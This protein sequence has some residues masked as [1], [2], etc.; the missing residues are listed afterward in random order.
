M[1]SAS[2]RTERLARLPPPKFDPVLP[3][4]SRREEIRA[5]IERHQVVIV[6]GETGS[7]KTTQLPKILLEMGRGAAGYIGHTQ[8]RR[9]AARSVAARIAEELN[10]EP[11]SVVGYKVRFHD[12]LHADS[13]VKLM[14][15]GILL[16]ETQSDPML[17]QYDSIIIDEAHERSLNIDFLLGYLKRL[18]PQR[19]DLKLVVTS[20]TI[21]AERFARHFGGAPVIEVSGRLYPVEMRYRPVE[22][23][24]EDTTRDEE[25]RALAAAVDELC[26]EGPGDVLV[27][28]PGEREIRDAAE[29]LRKHHP[30]HT[31]ILPLYS[32]LS[33]AE[34][35]R[36]FRPGAAR[37][38]VLA[39]NVAETS[40]TVPRIRYVV[41]T[42]LA[43]VK[44]YSYR[45]KVEQ[46]RVENVS[47][48]AATQRAGRCGR[49]RDGICVRL[50]SE[51]DYEGR[52]PYSEPEVLRSSLA[53]VILRA[54]SL[55]LGNVEEFPFL[56]PPVPRAIADGYALLAELG[57]VDEANELTDVGRELARLPLDPRVGR[58]LIAARREG[59]L[60][61]VLV[62]AAALSAQD[63]RLRPMENPAAAD[64]RHARYADE[65]SDFLA[66][67]KMWKL[68]EGKWEKACRENFI[69]I[70]R[71]REWRD[72]HGQLHAT[73]A[74]MGWRA[75]SADPARAEGY[76]AL[77]RALL[78][79]L[80]GNVGLRDEEGGGYTGARG[81]KFSVH[82]G[83]WAKKPGK[84]IVAA[85][86]VETTR[87]YARTVAS[88][89]T[90]WLEEL[91]AHLIKRH[92]ERPHWEKARAQVVAL[93][94][95]TLYGLPVYVNRR[96]HYGPLEPELAREIFIRSALVEGDFDTRAPFFEHNRRLLRDIEKLEHKSRRPDIL[97]DDGLIY[98]FYDA[99]LPEGLH[100]GADFEKWRKE[101]E[102]ANP[103][104][105]YLERGDLMRHEAAGITTENFPPR[106]QLGPNAFELEYHFEPGS[107][108]DGI[109]MTVAVALL[110]QVPA[111]RC[112]WLV[113]GLLKE[114]VRLLAKS[115]PQR[116]RHRL[117]PLEAFAE[118]FVAA[119]KPADVPLATALSR[120]IR[121][122]LNLEV[123]V[124]A[125]R[126][127]S[128]PPHLHMNFRVIDEHG[129]QLALGRNLGALKRELAGATEAVLQEQLPAAEGELYGSWTFGDLAE[130]MEIERGGRTMVGYPAL[131]DAGDGVTL[132]VFDSPERAREVHRAGVKRLLMIA[133]RERIRDIEKSVVKDNA[134]NLQFS[135]LSRE[136]E[137]KDEVVSAALER[138][139]LAESLPTRQSDFERRVEEG[140]SRLNLIAQEILRTIATIL[141]EHAQVHK[142]LA[143][144]GKAF[145]QAVE[146]VQAA[147]GRLLQ[148]HFLSRTPWE[149]VQQFPRYL[150]AAALRL[151]KLRADPVRDAR[152]MAE[153]A[154][155]QA[156]W[157]REYVARQKQGLPG[158][159][160]E[161][162]RW[163]LEELRV[164]LF[165]QGLRT[166]VPVSVKRLTKLWQ[167]IRHAQ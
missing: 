160:I 117:G 23:D 153:F 120:H 87:L 18:L 11:G 56:D 76:R 140:R 163:L 52:P 111:A 8:P 99:R 21:D 83:S 77:H 110:N 36:V 26:A 55:G 81:I 31:E 133:F 42:G 19:P 3:V 151:D 78:A 158:P 139:F 166:P 5:A 107:P 73:V 144:A 131:A 66:Y 143:A 114:K 141:A 93:E 25:E 62:I 90:Q 119:E 50:Y 142:R 155:L 10:T 68:F 28:L 35:D 112:E 38:I 88:I 70:P 14:T 108:R 106:L 145:P 59:C 64:E 103:R 9:I 84:W 102:R 167:S 152:L 146:D 161:Q 41:D 86:L 91:G 104:L 15:D 54:K 165:A 33:T 75:S 57:A 37:R 122:E 137:L 69:S 128:A 24:K 16:A 97:V 71:M 100:N 46:L 34:Q 60:D 147:I 130:I 125:F 82:P 149:R 109:T 124:D 47:Q 138:A 113:P 121:G 29:V 22:G 61:Q 98:A 92:R 96:I 49:V 39:T 2:S 20:A 44:R 74:E 150:K 154:P 27:F 7:G 135:Q 79:G 43:R 94:R 123:P 6:C 51:A 162:F 32:R 132:Q 12:T 67:L 58:M 95:G 156:A 17:R 136:V 101:A 129:R 53:A 164:S 105:L 157:Q 115:L 4:S 159:E 118:A 72:V 126:P 63:P 30:P 80:L 65:R 116:L 45:N 13:I 148:P 127:D 1:K 85:E 89:E 134:L 40:L 48:A